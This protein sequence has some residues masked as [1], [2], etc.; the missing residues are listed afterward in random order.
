MEV[1]FDKAMTEREETVSSNYVEFIVAIVMPPV[2]L[3]MNRGPSKEFV[4]SIILTML[5]YFPGLI[6]TMYILISESKIKTEN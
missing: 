1:E 5:G 3:L 6:Y 4:I 2:A